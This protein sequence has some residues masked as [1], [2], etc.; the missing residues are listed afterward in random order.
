MKTLLVRCI[1]TKNTF[2][3]EKE[4]ELGE[5]TGVRLSGKSLQKQRGSLSKVFC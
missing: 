4:R 5:E 2:E 3:R 1:R